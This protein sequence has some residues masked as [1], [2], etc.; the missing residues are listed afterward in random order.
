MNKISVL[1]V[2]DEASVLKAVSAVLK[3]ENID[4]VCA[5]TGKEA[6]EHINRQSFDVILLDIMMPEQDGLYFL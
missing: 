5:R 2:D 3:R 4:A 6:F 1:V